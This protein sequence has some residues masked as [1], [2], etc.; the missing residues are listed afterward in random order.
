M[1]TKTSTFLSLGLAALLAVLTGH[2]PARPMAGDSPLAPTREQR[3]ATRIITDYM[4]RYHYRAV[5]LDDELSGQVLDRYLEVLDPNRQVF[6][7]A[8][9][10]A[11]EVYRDRLDDALRRA[12]LEPAFVIFE[13]YRER[14]SDRVAHAVS[15]LGKDFDFSRQEY[16]EYDRSAAPWPADRAEWDDLWRR[17]VKNDVLSLRLAGKDGEEIRETLQRR[18][19][20]LLRQ[21]RQFSAEDVY[22]LF[23]NAYTATVEP[24][25][26]YFSPR[27][28]ENF[29]INMRL[30]L[31]GIGAALRSINEY[32]VVQRVIPGG[33]AD[34]DGRLQPE[35]RIV[36]VAQEDAD[37][38]DVVGWRLGDVVDLIRGA[39]G[40]RVR[41]Q[42]LPKGAAPDDPPREIALVRDTVRLESQ[43]ADSHIVDLPDSLGGLRIGVIRVPSFYLDIEARLRGDADYRSTTRDVRRLLAELEEEEVAGVVIDLRGNGGGSLEEATDLTGLFIRTGP[44]VQIR[45]GSGRITIK[46]DL[47]DELV[48][49]GP[50]A[51][52]VDRDSASASEIFAGAI[53][54]YRR[55]I[56]IGEPTF[57][58]GTVQTLIDLDA[59]ARGRHGPLGQ[60]KLTTAQ[61]FR[62]NGDST[63]FQGV[64]PD[65]L[66][67][68]PGDEAP[69][70]ERA[71]DNA[72]PW[73]RVHPARYRAWGSWEGRMAE[74]RERHQRR[75]ESDPGFRYLREELELMAE[76]ESRTRVSLVEA[77]RRRER[78]ARLARVEALEARY[79]AA[80]GLADGGDDHKVDL[81]ALDRIQ[82]EEAAR[83]LTDYI[84]VQHRQARAEAPAAIVP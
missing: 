8:D 45:D 55:G 44:V 19:E 7:A 13:R 22:Q 21:A 42:V 12:E 4:Q 80:L 73:A 60:L 77:E 26:A 28:S 39:K 79:R 53:Q 66:Y 76:G 83:I 6:L 75:T 67:P 15:L 38:V 16:Y 33:P 9:V 64:V 18:Y 58:K 25:T 56:I 52:L 48:Y 17:R 69:H 2:A 51:V 47:D 3:Q 32:T 30:S 57:G 63:Q 23:M 29:S 35:D 74:L 68:G 36:G 82:V 61:F 40:S 49:A 84:D 62:V 71:Y 24:H 41:L 37:F 27:T 11:F 78:E 20:T 43:A 70:G 1:K 10:S 65:I 31:E 50:L 34:L 72:L 81:E 54:D 5:A 14:L 46:R 59:A